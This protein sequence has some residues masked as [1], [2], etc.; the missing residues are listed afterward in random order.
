MSMPQQ[1][2]QQQQPLRTAAPPPPPP[3]PAPSS[4]ST[5]SQAGKFATWQRVPQSRVALLVA[6]GFALGAAPVLMHSRRPEGVEHPYAAAKRR[7]REERFAWYQSDDM[8]S[9]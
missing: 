8:P 4:A 9:K 3:Q 5:I 6:A 7:T 1:Q 2:Q